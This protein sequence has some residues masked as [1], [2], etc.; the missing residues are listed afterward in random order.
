MI[1]AM[2]PVARKSRQSK[3]TP[4][5]LE[6]SRKLKALW[7]KRSQLSQAEFGERHEIGNQSAVAQFLSGKVPLSLKAAR[8]FALGLGA[9]IYEFSS[10]LAEEATKTAALVQNPESDFVMVRR[11]AVTFSN[12]HGR[13]VYNEGEKAPLAFRREFLRSLGIHDQHASVADSAGNSNDPDIPNGA[14]LLIHS[15]EFARNHIIAGK[16][17]AFR[18][19]GDLFVKKLYQQKDKTIRATS[20]NP[21]RDTYP[22]VFIDHRTDD[23]E[24]IGRVVW[25]GVQL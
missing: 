4:E 8:G 11:V 22:D 18:R 7:D 21:D 15:A 17:Y 3:V 5:T 1:G 24:M 23:F 6:E 25:M 20:A 14:V 10:R 9:D 13:V 16:F 19:E 2:E 12:G